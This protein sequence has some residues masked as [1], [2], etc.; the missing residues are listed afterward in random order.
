MIVTNHTNRNRCEPRHQK[1]NA[2]PSRPG[3]NRRGSPRE[4]KRPCVYKKTQG[5][6]AKTITVTV[7]LLYPGRVKPPSCS[8]VPQCSSPRNNTSPN[9]GA[10]VSTP[11]IAVTVTS[12]R[13]HDRIPF[14]GSIPPR[15]RITFSTD[16]YQTRVG[17]T[18]ATS[19]LIDP[20]RRRR[21]RVLL[22]PFNNFTAI[23]WTSTPCGASSH[24]AARTAA[25]A[26]QCPTGL[27]TIAAPTGRSDVTIGNGFCIKRPAPTSIMLLPDRSHRDQPGAVQHQ[28]ISGLARDRRRHGSAIATRL[29]PPTWFYVEL[30]SDAGDS[31]AADRAPNRRLRGGVNENRSTPYYG[32]GNINKL[33]LNSTSR[34]PHR[35][36]VHHDP[37]RRPFKGDITV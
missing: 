24:R 10:N 3:S 28:R 36:P 9:G 21:H 17:L 15:C 12:A 7:D 11:E 16:K 14:R 30:H 2:I 26:T 29:S 19:T 20:Q 4:R 35:R 25:N 22:E 34:S 23:G 31:P 1:N 6:N 13:P 27:F 8:S 5:T 33:R 18:S 32:A 37:G